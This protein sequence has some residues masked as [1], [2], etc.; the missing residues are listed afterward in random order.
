MCA[1]LTGILKM[2]EPEEILVL[3]CRQEFC[4]LLHRVL[5]GEGLQKIRHGNV[6][7]LEDSPDAPSI[8]D[9]SEVYLVSADPERAERLIQ[10]LRACP[11]RGGADKYFA[12]YSIDAGT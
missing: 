4:R 7:Q 1:Q 11:I 6:S 9:G 5:Q 8:T 3:I 12:L 2:D 10:L